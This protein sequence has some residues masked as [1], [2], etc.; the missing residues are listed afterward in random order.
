MCIAPG[1]CERTVC[2]AGCLALACGLIMCARSVEPW[3]ELLPRQGFEQRLGQSAS[4]LGFGSLPLPLWDC[5]LPGRPSSGSVL[6]LSGLAGFSIFLLF[7]SSNSIFSL[8]SWHFGLDVCV[9]PRQIF[10]FH[11]SWF[12]L[13]DLHVWFIWCV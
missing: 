9:P 1:P 7:G 4:C 3:G 10:C 13:I 2:R 11:F 5:P 6:A 12:E 8:F